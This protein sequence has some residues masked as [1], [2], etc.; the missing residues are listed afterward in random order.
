M[1]M[2]LTV[3]EL[4]DA[5]D[6][7]ADCEEADTEIVLTRNDKGLYLHFKDYPE[8]GMFGPLGKEDAL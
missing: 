8:E 3:A 2:N 1:T 4:R 6:I 7:C 5:L